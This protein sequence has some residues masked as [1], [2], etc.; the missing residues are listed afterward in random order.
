MSRIIAFR[1]WH[2]E[3]KT[4]RSQGIDFHSNGQIYAANM[5]TTEHYII[6]QSTGIKDK[7]GRWVV[8]GDIVDRKPVNSRAGGGGR[9]VIIWDANDHRFALKQDNLYVPTGTHNMPYKIVPRLVEVIGNIY[10]NP[11]LIRRPKL[12]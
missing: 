5:N 10:E 6:M 4:M 8:E 1:F 3:S 11:E 9:F 12:V 7:N 2:K